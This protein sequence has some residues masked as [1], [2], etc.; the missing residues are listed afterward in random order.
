MS[1]RELAARA[2]EH[3]GRGEAEAVVQRERSGL[4]R[5]AASEVH[6]PTLIDNVVVQLQ[7]VLDGRSGFATTNRLDDAGLA[8]LAQRAQ[9]A[10]EV[11][12]ARDDVPAL[13]RPAPI[14]PIEGFDEATAALSA[15]EQAR[16]ASAAISAAEGSDLYGFFTSGECGL[17][18][19]STAGVS[20][21]ARTTDA[22]ALVLAAGDDAS[23]YSMRT[24]WRAAEVDVE[25]AARE[26]CAKAERTVGAVE[27]EPGPYRTVLE[28]YAFGELLQWFSD[29]AFGALDLLEERSFLAG[30]LGER[31][32]D[33]KVSI[34]DDALDAR[35]LPKSF[36][37]EGT[38]KR[39][40]QLV[41]DGVAR[42]VV[43]DRRTA[44]QAGG[45][46]ESTGHALPAPQR[47]YGPLATALQVDPGD[48][49]SLEDLADRV[50]DGLYV[51]RLHYLGIVNPR[52]GVL[53]GMTRDGTFRIRNGRVAEP[54]VNLRFTVA[55][56][57]VLADLLGLTRARSLVSQSDFYGDR[58]A[59]A[60]LT[61]A[62]ATA[63]FTITGTGSRPGI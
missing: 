9:A 11:S 39:R 19:C 37:H 6:Q 24:S 56:P 13:T 1:D 35:G 59:F 8:D 3:V 62:V 46:A 33:E 50:G 49:E 55:V 20:A 28:P 23:G 45:D 12:P 43:W 10:A 14:P 44:A 48:A 53:T 15:E 21:E 40:V 29:T 5:F 47:S 58:D 63:R 32:F 54:L 30:R 41:E 25:D 38:P 27:L 26:A 31:L 18:I 42:G 52:E 2:L 22:T 16:R 17:A 34:A 36:D 61:P 57:D 51:T 4:A 60:V 7:V